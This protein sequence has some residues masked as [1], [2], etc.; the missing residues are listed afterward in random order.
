M[1][2]ERPGAARRSIAHLPLS[3]I[4]GS[5]SRSRTSSFNPLPRLKNSCCGQGR[6]PLD[7][8]KC[9]PAQAHP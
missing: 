3:T 2:N 8:G 5:L 4:A 9:R 7:T 6:E 1:S